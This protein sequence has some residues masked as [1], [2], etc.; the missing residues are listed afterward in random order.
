MLQ[1]L[2]RLVNEYYDEDWYKYSGNVTEAMIAF[3]KVFTDDL[4]NRHKG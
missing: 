2:G 1:K 3:A 4:L